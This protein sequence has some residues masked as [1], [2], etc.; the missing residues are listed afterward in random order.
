M[1]QHSGD[2]PQPT[3]LCSLLPPGGHDTP[4]AVR[5]QL[6]AA[7]LLRRPLLLPRRNK[8]LP[9]R[10]RRRLRCSAKWV[11]LLNHPSVV[12]CSH[13]TAMAEQCEA[14][15]CSAR[16]ASN[17]RICRAFDSKCDQAH[18]PPGAD[19]ADGAQQPR[20]RPCCAA[21]QHTIAASPQ[22]PPAGGALPTA[23][24]PPAPPPAWPAAALQP[25]STPATLRP[26]AAGASPSH[27]SLKPQFWGQHLA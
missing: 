18:N 11:L 24:G 6:P 14:R 4:R 21:E 3:A 8:L 9:G 5:L 15:N 19:A 23:A 1:Q 20:R 27:V 25:P 12:T 13:R 22:M 10:H 2:A 7:F 17:L 26:T 16:T